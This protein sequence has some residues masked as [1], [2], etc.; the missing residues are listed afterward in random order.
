M[1]IQDVESTNDFRAQ[2]T[3]SSKLK[4]DNCHPQL[5]RTKSASMICAMKMRL[6][7]SVSL[8]MVIQMKSMK[9]R[10]K[11]KSNGDQH[12]QAKAEGEL[13]EENGFPFLSSSVLR[14]QFEG[15]CLDCAFQIA[16]RSIL[17]KC[18]SI[19]GDLTVAR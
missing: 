11:M 16:G 8:M 12:G 13:A 2:S 17:T 5:K 14:W 7:Q 4:N 19:E 3:F 9:V 1:L 6:I 18:S 10:R 15:E